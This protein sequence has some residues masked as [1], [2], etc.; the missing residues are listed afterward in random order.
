[1]HGLLEKAFSIC[2]VLCTPVVNNY[3]F[4]LLKLPKQ[5]IFT[6]VES[7]KGE[8]QMH[9]F[10]V[11][12]AGEPLAGQ[13]P[14]EVKARI[15]QLFRLSDDKLDALFSGKPR[16][17]KANL[18]AEEAE[19]YRQVFLKAGGLVTIVPAGSNPPVPEP[20]RAPMSRPESAPDGIQLSPAN[21]GS[22]IDTA[23]PI[24]TFDL[25]SADHLSLL[26]TN[27]PPP[28]TR[29]KA[30]FD[31]KNAGHFEVLPANAGS[32][33]DCSEKKAAVQLPDISSIKL[34]E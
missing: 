3:L 9:G 16:R 6:D 30:S 8:I 26:P 31:L 4:F 17:I 34:V 13:D 14:A 2:C 18:D 32:L 7:R 12:F 33:E 24:T 10:D 20:S 1:M 19:K 5:T 11:Y 22:L 29:V 15:G 28:D 23:K 27:A 21:T 25:S